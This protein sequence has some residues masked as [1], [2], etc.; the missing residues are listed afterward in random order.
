MI[1]GFPKFPRICSRFCLLILYSD[2]RLIV[3][4]Q[5]GIWFCWMFSY[6]SHIWAWMLFCKRHNQILFLDFLRLLWCLL[7]IVH[8]W[9][10]IFRWAAAAAYFNV[11]FIEQ[12]VKFEVSREVLSNYFQ[13][14][15]SDFCWIFLLYG[16]LN[17]II[18]LLCRLLSLFLLLIDFWYV[19]WWLFRFFFRASW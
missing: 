10:D 3:L 7:D 19:N 5:S 8:Y 16:G 11:V 17:Q 9:L 15:I 6:S 13:E 4:Y 14:L 18:F 12:L 1:C 2:I